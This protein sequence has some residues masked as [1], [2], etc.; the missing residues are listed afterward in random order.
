MENT[1]GAWGEK[2]F[3]GLDLGDERLNKRSIRLAEQLAAKPT[4]SIPA[5]TGSWAD[6]M[7][8]YRF[9]GNENTEWEKILAPHKAQTQQR[10]SQHPVVLCIQG[11]TEL[12]F[13]GQDIRGLGSLSYDAQRGMYP[14]PTYVVTPERDP[15]GITASWMW[16][17][18]RRDE[19]KKAEQSDNEKEKGKKGSR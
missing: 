10:M 2:E 12:D 5:A 17:R 15:L 11:T 8:A 18:E 3:V 6:T 7:G 19:I 13:N 1:L 14:H 16:A 4:V 9:F